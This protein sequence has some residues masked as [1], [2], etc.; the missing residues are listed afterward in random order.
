MIQLSDICS[1]G[2]RDYYVREYPGKPARE[3]EPGEVELCRIFI[4][5]YCKPHRRGHSS[6]HFKHV[7]ENY[8]GTYIGNGSFIAAAIMEGCS[9]ERLGIGPNV[10]VFLKY[11]SRASG[12]G[13]I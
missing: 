6:Y 8:F 11:D 5:E 1:Y 10:R 12:N 4:R 2:F 13:G 3:V 7:V 9:M